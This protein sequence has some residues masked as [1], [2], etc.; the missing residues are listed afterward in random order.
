MLAREPQPAHELFPPF[1]FERFELEAG[2]PRQDELYAGPPSPLAEPWRTEAEQPPISSPSATPAIPAVRG[3]ERY[4]TR[5]PTLPGST[6][7]VAYT[8]ALLGDAGT[9]YNRGTPALV[10]SIVSGDPS[11]HEFWCSGLSLW[12]LAA[13][14]Y[15][16]TAPL[17]GGDGQSFT[18]SDG[19]TEVKVTLKA[20]IDGEPEAVE[21]MTL[22]QQRKMASGG[23]IGRLGGAG[24]TIGHGPG[25]DAL[26]VKGAAGAFQIA[27]IGAE[28][29]ELAQKPGDFAQARWMSPGLGPDTSVKHWGAGHA[30]Q[31][32]SVTARGSALFGKA[33]SPRPSGPGTLAGWHDDVAFTI[34]KDT[35]PALV[36]PH[37]VLTARRIEANLPGAG[38]LPSSG[39]GGVQITREQAVPDLGRGRS[40]FVVYYGRLGTSPWTGWKP[41]VKP[42]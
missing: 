19:R 17:V 10:P 7:D 1:A 39:D 3:D 41:A 31:V 20:I 35:N 5:P 23:S 16:L 42:A 30:W 32:W 40:G 26:A 8:R 34:D 25:G 11:A 21:A 33:G 22:A 9:S 4:R 18:W 29:P 6:L 37:T 28:V 38:T 14:G 24:H 2:G 12:T 13:T 15:D 36:G 27:G